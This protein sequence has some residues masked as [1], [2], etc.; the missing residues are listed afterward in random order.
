MVAVCTIRS[1]PLLRPARHGTRNTEWFHM[2]NVGEHDDEMWDEQQLVTFSMTLGQPYDPDMRG[3][4]YQCAS[5]D[6]LRVARGVQGCCDV[7]SAAESIS[8]GH[9][10]P[11][12]RTTP[13]LMAAPLKIIDYYQ[14][15]MGDDSETMGQSL[16]DLGSYEVVIG[17][18]FVPF[19]G[20]TVLQLAVAHA[21]AGGAV[22][23]TMI[24]LE[25]LLGRLLKLA[26]ADDSTSNDGSGG[27][28]LE[29]LKETQ[30]LKHR[31]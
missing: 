26:F 2:L 30:P 6:K 17:M 28:D 16:A 25:E 10:E 29:H 14:F 9:P 23:L 31:A 11:V 5:P 21:A 24:S 18:R 4:A 3:P 8:R 22:M 13:P 7:G 15:V 1:D 19:T 20:Q 12:S 27:S